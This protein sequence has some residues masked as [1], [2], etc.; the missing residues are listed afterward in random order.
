MT[1]ISDAALDQRLRSVDPLDP[2]ALPSDAATEAVLRR[3]L[4]AGPPAAR[5]RRL[6]SAR[7]RLLAGATAAVAALAAGLVILLGSSATS[8]AFAV[9][10]NPD[11]TVT[12][13]LITL[14]GIAG[15][16][17]KLAAMG[18]RA[19]IL[20]LVYEARYMA[21]IH[22]C[23]GPPSAMVHTVTFDPAKIPRRALLLLAPV[24]EGRV[25]YFSAVRTRNGDVAKGT[26]LARVRALAAAKASTHSGKFATPGTSVPVT[27]PST[28]GAR[29]VRVY[30]PSTR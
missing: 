27:V 1:E 7:I 6:G 12:V 11:G 15:A 17:H 8:P 30:C 29:T 24:R 18:V 10:H 21:S 3:L 20:N 19:R 5:T 2:R 13:R 9:T 25:F 22:P 16:N 4:T 23:Q 28:D 14:W 26:L